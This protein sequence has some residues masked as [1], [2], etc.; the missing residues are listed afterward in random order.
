MARE[1]LTPKQQAFV[2]AYVGEARGNATQAARLAGY[3]GSD[4]TLQVT[5]HEVLS[6]PKVSQAI[7]EHREKTQAAGI[8]SAIECAVLLSGMATGQVTEPAQEGGEQPARIKDRVAAINVL[9]KIR[10]YEAATKT[11]H[12]G[13]VALEVSLTPEQDAALEQWL[14]VRDDE[15][16]A[17]RLRELGLTEASE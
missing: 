13:T 8:L 14:A 5:G 16:I 4:R 7:A 6:N 15:V 12:S 2:A 1:G 10:G 17:D 11:E 3:S 9:A